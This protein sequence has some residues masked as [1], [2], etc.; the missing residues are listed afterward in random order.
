M[1]PY[2]LQRAGLF[3]LNYIQ[4]YFPS[5]HA[6]FT[7]MLMVKSLAP[8]PGKSFCTCVPRGRS[9]LKLGCVQKTLKPGAPLIR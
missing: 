8:L 7:T 4:P 5:C 1:R 9:E 6:S 2:S 3:M